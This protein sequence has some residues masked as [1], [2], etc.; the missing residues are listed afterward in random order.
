MASVKNEAGTSVKSH[1]LSQLK[2]I[3]SPKIRFKG[4]NRKIRYIRGSFF[5]CEGTCGL[6]NF[7]AS[8]YYIKTAAQRFDI[9]YDILRSLVLVESEF[10]AMKII[11]PR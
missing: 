3:K 9:I 5:N 11:L 10:S 2:K 1:V 7:P 8:I 6:I 4:K